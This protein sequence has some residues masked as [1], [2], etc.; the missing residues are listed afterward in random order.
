MKLII[1]SSEV[2]KLFMQK[3]DRIYEYVNVQAQREKATQP[4]PSK[5]WIDND[6]ACEI[7]KVSKRTMQRLRSNGRI[8]YSLRGGVVRYTRAEIDRAMN[9]RTFRS[10]NYRA[11]RK[12]KEATQ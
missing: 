2:W 3:I 12:N 8:T 10:T 9:G 11:A 1:V 6:E 4:D 5:E 7:L